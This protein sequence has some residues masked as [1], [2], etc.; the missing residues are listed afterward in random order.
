MARLGRIGACIVMAWLALTIAARAETVVADL[1]EHQIK[2]TT[3]FAGTELLLFGVADS[4]GDII[5]TVSGPDNSVIVRRKSR[6]SGLWINAESVQFETVP[7][8]YHVAA[9]EKLSEAT[10]DDVLRENG[11][12]FRYL[13]LTPA[14]DIGPAQAAT[15][16]EALLRRK[17]VLDLYDKHPGLI[18]FV[19]GT[20][21]RTRIPFPANVPTGTYRV[22]VYHVDNG[23]VTSTT[24]IPLTV[25][26]VGLEASIFRFAHD[27]P[28]LYGIFAIAL[29][30]M[31]GY[32][33]GMVF[34]RR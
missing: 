18:E 17:E 19:S 34:G 33:A 16:R 20:L 6:V 24:S 9:T 15:F 22:D 28:A 32:G 12:G 10:L 21:F 26:K 2:I 29:A 27:Y 1:S 31:A 25:L 8:F 13:S 3:G 23:W 5:V 14:V 4:P 30:A 11:V 7:G